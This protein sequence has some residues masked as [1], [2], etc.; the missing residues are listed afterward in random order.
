[1]YFK[2]NENPRCCKQWAEI[3]WFADQFEIGC[4]MQSSGNTVCLLTNA[5]KT[6][7]Q[8]QK[9]NGLIKSNSKQKP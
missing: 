6:K 1:M 7:Q 9:K 8:Q 4:G 5:N 2:I 3:Y